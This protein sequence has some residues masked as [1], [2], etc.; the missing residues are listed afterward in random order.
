MQTRAGAL[1]VLLGRGNTLS[2][3]RVVATGPGSGGGA[4]APGDGDGGD[5]GAEG[6]GGPGGGPCRRAVRFA[7]GV[8]REGEVSAVDDGRSACRFGGRSSSIRSCGCGCGGSGGGGDGGGGAET[9][10]SGSGGCAAPGGCCRADSF[11]LEMMLR[12]LK[13]WARCISS[14]C[15]MA[16]SRERALL[17]DLS[18]LS[19]ELPAALLFCL[20]LEGT[21]SCLLV[22]VTLPS[23]WHL[24]ECAFI[25][26]ASAAA[27]LM[28]R[29]A[30]LP[31]WICLTAVGRVARS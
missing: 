29:R 22:N 28:S 7:F 9:L 8:L 16:R 6:G 3:R 19:R 12:A 4:L 11:H 13:S 17:A 27:C 30:R 14:R 2:S 5:G 21:M 10:C 23:A 20:A 18:P 31:H 1:Q 25:S 24:N 26:S 15:A